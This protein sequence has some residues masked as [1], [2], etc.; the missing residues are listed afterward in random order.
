MG[1][2]EATVFLCVCDIFLEYSSS[3]LKCSVSLGYPFPHPLARESGLSL[4]LIFSVLIALSG[5][6]YCST[7][8]LVYMRQKENSGT[9]L[10][11]FSRV[12][13]SLASLLPFL[14]LSELSCF[15]FMYNVHHFSCM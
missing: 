11:L 12:L 3:Y 13:R 7:P 4:G 14:H 5:L 6:S 2:G 9:H 15:Y 1:R 8:S 10:H